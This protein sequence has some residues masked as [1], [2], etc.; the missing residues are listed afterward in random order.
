MATAKER[1]YSKLISKELNDDDELVAYDDNEKEN[2]EDSDEEELDLA[3]FEQFGKE[4]PEFGFSYSQLQHVSYG[5]GLGATSKL[6]KMVQQQT[7]SKESIF[8]Q[9]LKQELLKYFSF[10]AIEHWVIVTTKLPRYWLKNPEALTET[11][12]M[13][14]QLKGKQLTLEYLTSFSASSNIS[15]EDLFRYYRFIKQYSSF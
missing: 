7:M 3:E 8:I 12:N 1:L 10:E 9:K 14:N 6:E 15:K 11:Y 5:E 13:I 2:D 4:Q